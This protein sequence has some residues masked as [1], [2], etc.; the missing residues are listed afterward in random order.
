M[1]MS[2]KSRTLN[3][4]VPLESKQLLQMTVKGQHY[5]V[6]PVDG[7]TGYFVSTCSQVISC[8]SS[9][10][11]Q[12]Q[13][14]IRDAPKIL[15][16]TDNGNGYLFVHLVTTNGVRKKV[17]VHRLVASNLL[18]HPQF[19][20]GMKYQVNHINQNRSDNR[21]CNLEW[22]TPSENMEWNRLMEQVEKE[23]K[24]KPCIV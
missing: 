1:K 17:Y 15:K 5:Y 13:R 4:A 19:V 10:N 7:F 6:S 11:G 2:E 20:K 14:F 21:A 3:N 24:K 9:F 22:V 12:R 18:K 23:R 16:Q 8:V